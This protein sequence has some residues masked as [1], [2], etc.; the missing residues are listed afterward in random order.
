M[1]LKEPQLPEQLE[2]AE[3]QQNEAIL[4]LIILFQRKCQI[5]YKVKAEC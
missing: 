5:T 1:A 3:S 4:V 2:E